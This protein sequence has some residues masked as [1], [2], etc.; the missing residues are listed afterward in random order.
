MRYSC[1][2]VLLA[3]L[4]SAC[5]PL[6]WAG[7]APNAGAAANPFTSPTPLILL[8]RYTTPQPTETLPAEATLALVSP[9]QPALPTTDAGLLPS[10]T[11]A[12]LTLTPTLAAPTLE[13]TPIPQE[14]AWKICT[15]LADILLG[16]LTRLISDGYHPPPVFYSDARH[17][18][19]DIAFY[20]WKG[21]RQIA[22]T[23]V[24]SVLPGRVAVAEKDSF[25]FGN[26]VVVETDPGLIPE[27]V[28]QK[29]GIA[30]ARSL[31]LLYAH[32]QDDSLRVT[33]G[34]T[35]TACQ[36]I[37]Q[38]GKSGNTLAAHL[39]LETR[40]GPPGVQFAGFELYTKTA[41]RQ[42]QDN[43]RRWAT[44]GDF[45]HF[46]PL[47]LLLYDLGYVA[48]PFPSDSGSGN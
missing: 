14:M 25:P 17:P 35:V 33:L 27:A 11:L 42:A 7:Q 32:M 23:P 15:P 31:Y 26:V 16:D 46:D 44:S 18:A 28:K 1:F 10:P 8:A 21:I 41:S 39:H 37:G 9:T 3:I 4:T 47:R 22:G 12:P 13:N 48:T 30:A 5:D 2:L 19:I 40:I 24:Q 45:R 34:Q 38:V 29:L 6:S 43:Y 20:N 36:T